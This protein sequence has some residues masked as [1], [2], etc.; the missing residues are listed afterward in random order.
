MIVVVKNFPWS[1]RYSDSSFVN[2]LYES[3]KWSKNDYWELEW[4]LCELC[5]NFDYN[6][7]LR[8]PIFRLFSIISGL[9]GCHLDPNDGYFLVDV[10]REEV[11]VF[12]ERVQLVFEGFFSGVM[13]DLDASF[14]EKNPLLNS[15]EQTSLH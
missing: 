11:Y 7:D 2:G 12:R 14:D 10:G 5:S 6:S 13:P 3:K 15:P 9:I 8:W 1:D 4:A